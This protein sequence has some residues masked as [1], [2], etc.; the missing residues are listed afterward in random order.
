MTLGLRCESCVEGSAGG[1]RDRRL[2]GA[3][4]PHTLYFSELMRAHAAALDNSDRGYH[5]TG[6]TNDLFVRQVSSA[7]LQ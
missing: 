1:E 5:G 4:F 7:A 2:L 3:L 6:A